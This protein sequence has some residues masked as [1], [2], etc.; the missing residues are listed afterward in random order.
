MAA[1]FLA[2]GFLYDN[3][4]RSAAEAGAIAVAE[5]LRDAP[6]L[7]RL[8]GVRVTDAVRDRLASAA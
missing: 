3:A 6:E 2:P 8:V 4:A 1:Y 7:V 5:P